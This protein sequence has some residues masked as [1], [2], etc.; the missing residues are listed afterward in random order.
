MAETPNRLAQ[1]FRRYTALAPTIMS[2]LHAAWLLQ[3]LLLGT[4]L[5]APAQAAPEPVATQVAAGLRH[6]CALLTTGGVKC[7]GSNLNGKLGD[8]TT[9]DRSLPVDVNGL[10][11]G[12]ATIAVGSVHTCALT[13][14]GGVKCWGGG[15][16][17]E[18]GTGTTA[19]SSVPVDV[20]G[21]TSGVAAIGAGQILMPFHP[22]T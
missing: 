7:W 1:V 20:S 9:T 11:N 15:S 13:T 4:V 17:G 22:W 3:L 18:L 12:V 5:S 14:S 8:G 21:L 16:Q 6:S 2:F 10:S 19:D